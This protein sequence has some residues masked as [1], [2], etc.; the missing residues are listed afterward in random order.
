MPIITLTTDLG[1]KDH[2]VGIVK[3][4]IYKHCQDATIVDI[5]HEIPPFNILQAA[6]TLKNS[7][8]EFPEGSIHIVGVN[9][10]SSKESEHLVIKHEGHYFIGANNGIF[11]LMFESIPEEAYELTLGPSVETHTFPT[12]EVYTQAACHIAKGG[13]IEMLGRKVEDVIEKTLFRAV[14]MGDIIK[15]MVIHVDHYGNIIT[16]IEETF[17]KAFGQNRDFS[18]EFRNGSYDITEISQAYSDVAEGEKLA[19]FSSANLLEVSI[20]QGNASKLLGLKN[21]DT[22]RVKFYDR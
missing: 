2:Y 11:P 13:T 21:L 20:N 4:N 12:K 19:L 17:F 1:L 18:I 5:T 16:N 14:S 3:G 6:F 22:I 10:E 9:P 8:Q 15:G 7:Y